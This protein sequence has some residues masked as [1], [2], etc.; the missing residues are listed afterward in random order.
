PHQGSVGL[1]ICGLDLEAERVHVVSA[2]P[3]LA[4]GQLV[5]V[6][7]PGAVLPDGRVVETVVRGGIESAG[8]LFAEGGLDLRRRAGRACEPPGRPAGTPL[9]DVAGVRDTVIELEITANRGDLLSIRGVARDLAAVL[10]LRVHAPRV[11]LRERGVPAAQQVQ[12]R[13]TAPDLCPRYAARVV[14]GVTVGPSPCAMRMRL[15]RAGMRPINAI[16]DATNLVMLERGQPLHA[17]D[18][19]HVRDGTIIVRRAAAGERLVTLDGVERALVPD[20]L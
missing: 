5:A 14:R 17:F 2:A 18:L 7:L 1:A 4:A 9:R 8:G 16:V 19:A 12:V 3:G 6:A 10:G 15:L 11:R 20:D 13:I